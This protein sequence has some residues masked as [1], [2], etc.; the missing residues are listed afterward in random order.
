MN[1]EMKWTKDIE[2]G[3]EEIDFQH[4]KF[5]ELMNALLNLAFS[6]EEAEKIPKSIDMIKS[7]IRY[8]FS[9]E[10]E[11]MIKSSYHLYKEHLAAHHYFKEE[12]SKMECLLKD[13][14]E[15]PKALITRYN[16]MLV[17]WF[18]KHI[19]VMDKRMSVHLKEFKE[20]N[21]SFISK[22]SEILKK[23]FSS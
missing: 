4:R 11:L 19:K 3:I 22:M 14:K 15:P 20:K 12:I 8:H 16:Y 1:E 10:E 5:F 17:E 23:P 6:G 21:S 9:M 18:L 2:T 13:Q 7:Y